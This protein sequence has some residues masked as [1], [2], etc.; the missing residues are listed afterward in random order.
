MSKKRVSYKKTLVRVGEMTAAAIV[1]APSTMAFAQEEVTDSCKELAAA[2]KTAQD[3]IASEQNSAQYSISQNFHT[4]NTD[5]TKFKYKLSSGI[6][7]KK[8]KLF[9]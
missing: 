1:A 7:R 2:E 8:G 6:K 3:A 9:S 4:L 5:L